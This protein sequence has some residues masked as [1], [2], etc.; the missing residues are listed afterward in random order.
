MITNLPVI[1]PRQFKF[2]RAFTLVEVVIASSIALTLAGVV[3][4]LL[5]STLNADKVSERFTNSVFEARKLVLRISQEMISARDLVY[6]VVSEQNRIYSSDFIVFKDSFNIITVIYYDTS[7]KE[8][9]MLKVNINQDTGAMS[10]GLDPK[11]LGHNIDGLRF[12]CDGQSP[13]HIQFRV[14]SRF[15]EQEYH[16]VGGIRM[17]NS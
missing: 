12:S 17:L 8:V 16:L 4:N 1:E 6:P 9:R 15:D 13:E 5:F 3:Y 14:F 11:A 7:Q 10:L 2:R